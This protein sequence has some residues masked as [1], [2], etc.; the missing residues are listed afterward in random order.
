M[1]T[2]YFPADLLCTMRRTNDRLSKRCAASRLD[3]SHIGKGQ[4]CKPVFPGDHSRI[5]RA[6]R[7]T[8]NAVLCAGSLAQECGRKPSFS[9][10]ALWRHDGRIEVFSEKKLIDLKMF[11]LLPTVWHQ[12]ELSPL[13]KCFKSTQISVHYCMFSFHQHHR[14]KLTRRCCQ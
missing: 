9:R 13:R 6:L 4:E 7:D 11:C 12:P 10:T 1:R 2:S 8:A 5:V 14:K 3:G